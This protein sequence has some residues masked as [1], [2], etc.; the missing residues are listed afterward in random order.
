MGTIKVN[1]SHSGRYGGSSDIRY[2]EKK[3]YQHSS[4]GSGVWE[5]S[6]KNDENVV[7]QYPT[8]R[9]FCDEFALCNCA[10]FCGRNVLN[11]GRFLCFRVHVL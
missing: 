4:L 9:L 11:N 8:S 7:I 2:R 3:I 1:L 10:A 5:K 6:W